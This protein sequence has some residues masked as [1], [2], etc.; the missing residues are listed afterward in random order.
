MAATR[1]CVPAAGRN[2][3]KLLLL[4]WTEARGWSPCRNELKIC[5]PPELT[6][7]DKTQ[8]PY[9][10]WS[11]SEN[12]PRNPPQGKTLSLQAQRKCRTKYAEMKP[13]TPQE[14]LQL[15]NTEPR[16][17][18]STESPAGIP[19]TEQLQLKLRPPSKD[20]AVTQ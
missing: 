14:I 8:K 4:E 17:Q 16:H 7:P 5:R 9:R 2:Y 10:K 11:A 18:N 3:R 1:N 12:H 19:T 15:I 13:Q 6:T 20:C